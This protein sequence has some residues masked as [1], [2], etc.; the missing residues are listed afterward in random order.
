M[1]DRSF[2]PGEVLEA[3]LPLAVAAAAWLRRQQIRAA[4]GT[5]KQPSQGW[6][7]RSQKSWRSRTDRAERY[8]VEG[9]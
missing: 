6:G 4:V 9:S 7:S 5:N 1:G 8:E 3:E 2:F